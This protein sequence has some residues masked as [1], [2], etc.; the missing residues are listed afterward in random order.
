MSAD[1]VTF[2]SN[3]THSKLS[4]T[5]E[6]SPVPLYNDKLKNNNSNQQVS[7]LQTALVATATALSCFAIETLCYPFDTVKV[8][9]QTTKDQFL[10]YFKAA[11]N[12][13]KTE[14]IRTFFKGYS[15][16]IPCCLLYNFGWFFTYE[17]SNLFQLNILNSKDLKPEERKYAI[18]I[19]PFISGAM[20]EF[21]AM[22]MY[23]PFNI[24]KVRMQ[25]DNPKYHYK[26][27]LD[28]TKKVY[29]GEGLIKFFKTFELYM[30]ANVTYSGILM[31]LYE[32]FRKL[33]L[34]Q[35][36]KTTLT[37]GE[38]WGVTFCSSIC[39]STIIN[40]LE[41]IIARYIVESKQF[42]G[43]KRTP[44]KLVKELVQKEGIKGFYKGLPGRLISGCANAFVYMPTFEY[45]RTHYGVKL[46]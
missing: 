46:E 24:P 3:L 14:G 26:S 34:E 19:I 10:P 45:L 7:N 6:E 39:C 12:F 18:G 5:I 33:L 8:R 17:K 40:P 41:V 23:I 30:Y 37:L 36:N 29:Q 43:E 11:R 4:H 44:M 25:V 9:I 38:T 31:L 28:G 16:L 13:Y 21:I 2:T 1:Q 15:G 22:S 20:A 42:N 32:N 27:V 35:K